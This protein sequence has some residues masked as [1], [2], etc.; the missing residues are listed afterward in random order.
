[1]KKLL[2][3][4]ISV[5]MVLAILSALIF[6]ITATAA[7]VTTIQ[8]QL[9]PDITI[10]YNG[11]IQTMKN[12]NGEVVYPLSY[13]GTTYLPVRAISGLLNLPV[14]WDGATSTVY[15]G[16]KESAGKPFMEAAKR[17]SPTTS[18]RRLDSTINRDEF[19]VKTDD[20]G[21]PLNDPE[22]TNALK[23]TGW[24][25]IHNNVN[26]ATSST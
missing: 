24:S 17:I 1:M 10:K 19:P 16:K 4:Q 5:K 8:A 14:D 25:V 21:N 11:E 20:F 22:F 13:N 26:T 9:R 23:T 15:L 7:T 12:A 2:K 6:S 3:K 18:I